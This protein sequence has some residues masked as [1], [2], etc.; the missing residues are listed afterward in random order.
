MDTHDLISKAGLFEFLDGIRSQ[1]GVVVLT[2]VV[3]IGLLGVTIQQL[4]RQFWNDSIKVREREIARLEKER[5][6]YQALVFERLRTT[7]AVMLQPKNSAT[8][9]EHVTNTSTNEVP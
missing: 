5:D 1:Y 6:T 8:A 4:M 9:N 7:E 2:L 3:I